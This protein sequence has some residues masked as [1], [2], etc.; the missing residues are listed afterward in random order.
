MRFFFP[1]AD[2]S[3]TIIQSTEKDTS[4]LSFNVSDKDVGTNAEYTLS[5]GDSS[6]PFSIADNSDLVVSYNLEAKTYDVVVVV[7]DHGDTPLSSSVTV[8]VQVEP[9]N[10]YDPM[11]SEDYYEF[12][13]DESSVGSTFD[14]NVTDEDIGGVDS[15]G[16]AD[17]AIIM[18]SLYSD[19]FNISSSVVDGITNAQLIVTEPFDRELISTFNLTIQAF[20]TGYAE[21]RRTSEV[22]VI[23][24]IGD[25][26][27]HPPVFDKEVFE[28]VVGEN[29]SSGHQ[30]F[31][32]MAS[33]EDTDLDSVLMYTLNNHKD[34]FEV[35]LSSG[36]L[37]VA[38][39]LNRQLQNVYLLN[40]TVTDSAG[41]SD[42]ATVNVTVTEVNDFA[43]QFVGVPDVVTINEDADY[44]LNF[45]VFD[46]DSEQAGEF[47]VTI[48]QSPSNATYFVLEDDYVLTLQKPLDYEVWVEPWKEGGAMEGRGSMLGGAIKGEN[49]VSYC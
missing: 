19:R 44:S 34:V 47:T 48:E 13:F 15:P 25:V 32:L 33:D 9:S 4:L 20:D 38:S 6:L 28:A 40:V 36:W 17:V 23:I 3:H 22:D 35:E 46:G 30:F 5:V 45:T 41:Q 31:Q 27:D 39:S 21:Y 2:L 16:I 12:T 18:D 29:A 24:V 14:F 8:S 1:R 10:M 42:T 43:P 37:K 49:R 26:N 11:F 7:T